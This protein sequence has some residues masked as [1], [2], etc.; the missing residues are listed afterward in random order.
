MMLE[1][2][3]LTRKSH[4]ENLMREFSFSLNAWN[5]RNPRC[6]FAQLFPSSP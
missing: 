4:F 6:A 1:S 3:D 5:L 2:Y